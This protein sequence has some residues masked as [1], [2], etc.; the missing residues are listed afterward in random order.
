MT[1]E[2][3]TQQWSPSDSFRNACSFA[4]DLD[5]L[6]SATESAARRKALDEA[7]DAAFY[8]SCEEDYCDCKSEIM[9]AIRA[10]IDQ[11]PPPARG[12]PTG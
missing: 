9:N 1:R 10:L 12:E 2:E 6:L 11:P 4:T 5:S 8:H 3:F 7:W